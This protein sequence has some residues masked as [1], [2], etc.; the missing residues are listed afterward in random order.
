VPKKSFP[1]R[2]FFYSPLFCTHSGGGG[3]G[4]SEIKTAVPLIFI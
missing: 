2:G 3:D 1:L 4:F